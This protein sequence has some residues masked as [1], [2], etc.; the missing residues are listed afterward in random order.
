MYNFNK[1]TPDLTAKSQRT[2]R[3]KGERG[4]KEKWRGKKQKIFSFFSIFP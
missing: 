4:E 1:Q 2:Q 3:R